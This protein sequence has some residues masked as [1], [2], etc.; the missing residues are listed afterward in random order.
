MNKK[1]LILLLIIIILIIL[2][3]KDDRIDM[4][5]HTITKYENILSEETL[6]LFKDYNFIKGGIYGD[7]IVDI[8][9]YNIDEV[10][11]SKIYKNKISKFIEN[12]NEDGKKQQIALYLN[13]YPEF[14]KGLNLIKRDLSKFYDIDNNV[15]FKLR[16]SKTPWKYGAH[17]DCFDGKLLQLFNQ[18]K[19]AT[20]DYDVINN[21]Y[22]KIKN[23]SIR[24]LEKKYKNVNK[25]ILNAGDLIEI[26]LGITHSTEGYNVSSNKNISILLSFYFNKKYNPI[27]ENLFTK[28]FKRRREEL[29]NGII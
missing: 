17:F 11:I 16:I 8:F 7:M 24:D 21:D 6:E 10:E 2:Y 12:N 14:N 20:L 9:E 22:F 13:N 3:L 25:T 29:N 1:L 5:K 15:K 4:P 19:V 26:P 23:S 28:Y 18:R 27:C